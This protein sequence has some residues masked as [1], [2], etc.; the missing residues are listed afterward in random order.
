MKQ[1]RHWLE[2][3]AE[4]AD[5]P[6]E[7]V[8]RQ[9]LVELAGERRVLIE[10]HQGVVQYDGERICVRVT[11]GLLQVEGRGMELARMTKDQLIIRGRIDGITLRRRNCG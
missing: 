8:I 10:G 7:M 5:L 11:Y 6:G 4:Q 2:R 9:P 1:E 3:L